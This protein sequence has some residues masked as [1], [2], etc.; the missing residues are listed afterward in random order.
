RVDPFAQALC[1]AQQDLVA[2][3]VAVE[4]DSGEYMNCCM[5]MPADLSG[6]AKRIYKYDA[7]QVYE[8]LSSCLV[9]NALIISFCRSAIS[10]NYTKYLY[11][12]V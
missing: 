4:I 6:Y 12:G 8:G 9:Q 2:A 10:S 1:Q 5:G 11:C 7:V 3:G